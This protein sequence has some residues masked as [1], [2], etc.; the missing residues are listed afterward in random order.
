MAVPLIW[1]MMFDVMFF[2]LLFRRAW[3]NHVWSRGDKLYGNSWASRFPFFSL[4]LSSL[5]LL[6]CFCLIAI[7]A[8]TSR[9]CL[10]EREN[11]N[12]KK[13]RGSWV[14]HQTIKLLHRHFI[15]YSRI[16][17]FQQKASFSCV[18]NVQQ[19]VSIESSSS[20]STVL[21]SR[22]SLCF[23]HLLCCVSHFVITQTESS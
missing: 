22:S 9:K 6:R 11:C 14:T 3:I 8:V 15:N 23:T 13:S 7:Y 17:V 4:N 5:L 20:D 1:L 12:N 18:S 21:H 2:I 19:L 10:Y 16:K